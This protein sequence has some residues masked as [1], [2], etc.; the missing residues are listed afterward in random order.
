MENIF[1]SIYFA[2]HH[3]IIC[4][5]KC[6]NLNLHVIGEALAA[7][8]K[9]VENKYEDSDTLRR[10]KEISDLTSPAFSNQKDGVERYHTLVVS[11]YFISLIS[12][13][14]GFLVDILRE[15]I[16]AYPAKAGAISLRLS[17]IAD[18]ESLNEAV[19]IGVNKFL[20]E[21]VYKRPK[22]YIEAINQI[23]SISSVEKASSMWK[24]Y[25][26]FKA[27]RDIGIHDDWRKNETYVRKV[28]EVGGAVPEAEYLVP[29]ND[30][31][32]AAVDV[33]DDLMRSISEH[34]AAKFTA[35]TT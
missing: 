29:D 23:L 6:V 30:Y 32:V 20:N 19:E 10:I 9:N 4:L 31:F 35:S 3:R 25:V 22:E 34:C 13:F 5:Y 14:E 33:I 17:E 7:T 12:E 8:V 2:R 11:H 26:E 15:V 18:C 28:Q 1:K 27:R 24:Q 16:K 21:L